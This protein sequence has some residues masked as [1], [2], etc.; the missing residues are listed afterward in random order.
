[1]PARL[2][3]GA[4]ALV[5][6]GAVLVAPAPTLAQSFGIDFG[7][8][9]G[10][11][12]LDGGGWGPPPPQTL[13]PIGRPVEE[14]AHLR[15]PST[16]RSVTYAYAR[17]RSTY[18]LGTGI[19]ANA[20][21][22]GGSVIYVH[23]RPPAPSV[24]APGPRIIDVERERLDRAPHGT[25]GRSV[26]HVG[27][28]K[29]IRLAPDHAEG[30]KDMAA[31]PAPRDASD[32]ARQAPPAPALPDEVEPFDEATPSRPVEAAPRANGLEPWSDD[33]RRHCE[34]AHETF[35]AALGT[36]LGQD[37]RRRFCTGEAT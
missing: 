6:S 19:F 29:I 9:A 12:V 37:G 28:A 22:G 16:Q 34:S 35:D 27:S 24:P 33:W 7:A 30:G 15:R 10:E 25:N 2:H 26:I 21:P 11:E 14:R 1:M 5:L 31:L 4:L 32:R 18:F 17:P 13:R 3:L 36:Y 20:N 8:P 23:G